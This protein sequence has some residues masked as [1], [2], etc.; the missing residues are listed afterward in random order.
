[1]AFDSELLQQLLVEAFCFDDLYGN[2]RDKFPICAF[3][4][5]YIGHAAGTQFS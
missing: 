2:A 5:K 1:L 3:G 4:L